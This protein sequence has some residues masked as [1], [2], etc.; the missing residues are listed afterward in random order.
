VYTIIILPKAFDDISRLNKPVAQQITAKLEWLSEN[1]D[2]ITQ[3]TLK[4]R[5]AGLSKLRSGDYRIIYE[6]NHEAKV[7]TVHKVGHRREIYQ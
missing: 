5:W 3:L 4:G 6:I 7:I 1:M 2:S